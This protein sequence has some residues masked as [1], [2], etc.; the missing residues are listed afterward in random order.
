MQ[1]GWYQENDLAIAIED[2]S[3]RI[4]GN[5]GENLIWQNGSSLP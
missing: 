1:G 3:Y 4:A 2:H 5:F